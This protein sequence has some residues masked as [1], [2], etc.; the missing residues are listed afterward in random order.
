MIVWGVT[1]WELDDIA[2]KI[3][4]HVH[5]LPAG[6]GRRGEPK[7]DFVLKLESEKYRRRGF[8]GRRIAA[9]CWHGH[10]DFMLELFDRFPDAR[11]KSAMADYRGREDF[12]YS[13]EATGSRNIGSIREPMR[14]DE[15]CDCDLSEVPELH[16]VF[17][18][19]ER[20]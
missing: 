6:I 19:S 4:V 3:G 8:N 20:S 5:A 2:L 11:I 9:V 14:Y 15:A 10:R 13:F 16:A 12:L 18:Y 1:P 7:S 17:G